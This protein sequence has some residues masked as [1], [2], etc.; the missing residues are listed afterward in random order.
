MKEVR[1]NSVGLDYLIMKLGNYDANLIKL[2][3]K[4]IKKAQEL[5]EEAL[6]FAFSEG[7][8]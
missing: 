2:F 8:Q 5:E 7:K 3:I 4:D 6:Q 1:A